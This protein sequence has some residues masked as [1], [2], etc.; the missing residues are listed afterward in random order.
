MWSVRE[1]AGTEVSSGILPVCPI[2]IHVLTSYAKI[3]KEARAVP[4]LKKVFGQKRTGILW[5]TGVFQIL[6]RQ[7]NCRTPD[8]GLKD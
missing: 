7:H 4:S 8:M 6:P 2:I 3:K 1:L 5:C